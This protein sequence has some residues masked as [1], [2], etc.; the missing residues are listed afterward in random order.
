MAVTH[1]RRVPLHKGQIMLALE[2]V[3]IGAKARLLTE[4]DVVKWL[5]LTRK[6]LRAQKDARNKGIEGVTVES[7]AC[8]GFVPNSYRGKAEATWLRLVYSKGGGWE[9]EVSRAGGCNSSFGR[10]DRFKV[11]LLKTG[12]SKDERKVLKLTKGAESPPLQQIGR[13][14]ADQGHLW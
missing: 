5:G 6:A 13:Q 11:M 8:G 4:D 14:H 9:V 10:G 3:Q 1:T 7:R 2:E 12:A